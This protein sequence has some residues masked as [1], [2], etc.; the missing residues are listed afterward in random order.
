MK[1]Y[2]TGPNGY[3]SKYDGKDYAVYYDSK[4]SII[5][6]SAHQTIEDADKLCNLLNETHELV[7]KGG[8]F[9]ENINH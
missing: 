1:K 2:Y 4:Y 7:E 8:N 5:L 3:T 9:F 6:Y